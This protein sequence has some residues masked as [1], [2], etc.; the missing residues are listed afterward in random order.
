MQLSIG[1]VDELFIYQ[2]LGANG[3]K[4][5]E[6]PLSFTILRKILGIF[7]DM[8]SGFEISLSTHTVG[9]V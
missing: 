2:I 9:K 6:F 1:T 7:I 8:N 3:Q 4:R 5:V